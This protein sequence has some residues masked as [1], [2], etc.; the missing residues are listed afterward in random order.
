MTVALYSINPHL[1]LGIKVS[2][3]NNASGM[4]H[5]WNNEK[6]A[7]KSYGMSGFLDGD[8]VSTI[9]EIGGT[10]KSIICVGSYINKSKVTTYNGKVFDKMDDNDIGNVTSF[11][12]TG[13]TI[14][15]RVKPDICAPGD[16]VI[17]AISRRDAYNWQT[18]VWPDTHSTYGRYV[19]E[20]GTS[21]SSPLVAG[22]VALLLE[23]DPKLTVDSVK[24]LLASTAIKDRFTGA[25]PIPDNRWGAGKINAYGALAKLLGTNATGR[26]AFIDAHEKF[27]VTVTVVSM[28]HKRFLAIHGRPQGSDRASKVSL[29][30]GNGHR[31]FTIESCR[32]RILL[33]RRLAKGVYLAHV[34]CNG[35][36]AKCKLVLW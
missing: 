25:L 26:S 30:D 14:D 16:M 20:T 28:A 7:F 31:L 33:P 17:G 35:Q 2:L 8:S 18:S 3:L 15:G 23:A 21:V 24:S 5:A 36:I 10:A 6:N 9:N 22:V 29:F 27:A 12:G 19:R 34:L 11:S 1:S 4:V 13:P 32:D